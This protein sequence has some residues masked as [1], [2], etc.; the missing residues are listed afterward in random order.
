MLSAG[1]YT[2]AESVM[3]VVGINMP[4]HRPAVDAR[5]FREDCRPANAGVA[6]SGSGEPF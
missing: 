3:A 1:I 5:R 6:P 2:Q 4:L